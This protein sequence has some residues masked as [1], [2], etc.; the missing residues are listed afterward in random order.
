MRDLQQKKYKK[1]IVTEIKPLEHFYPA[2]EYHQEYLKKNPGGYCHINLSTRPDKNLLKSSLT[3]LQY[4]VTQEGYTEPPYQNEYTDNEEKGIYVDVITGEPLFL[5][6]DKYRSGCGWPAF[7]RPVRDDVV[8]EVEDTSHNMIRTEVRSKGSDAHLGHVF[9]D[10]PKEAGGLR[11]C[12]NSAALKFIPIDQMEEK[13]YGRYI[14]L[15]K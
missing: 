15:V 13:G 11:Y 10:G 12:I 8:I 2:D 6:S 9:E 1:P 7:T 4:A 3:K 5:S 14:P